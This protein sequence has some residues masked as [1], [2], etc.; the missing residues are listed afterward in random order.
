[1]TQESG[2]SSA[3]PPPPKQFELFTTENVE[4]FKRDPDSVPDHIARAMRPPDLPEQAYSIFGEMWQ[5]SDAIQSLEEAGVQRLYGQ[6]YN[7]LHE[8]RKL[9]RSLLLNFLELV[10]VMSSAPEQV[11]CP[12]PDLP[13]AWH[14]LLI[15]YCLAQSAVKE[16]KYSRSR[17]TDL[18]SS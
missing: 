16:E 14:I 12:P 5:L 7:L 18:V 6:D 4:A 1:M 2:F 17:L 8:L 15:Y 11:I 3:F 10:T 9:S 13:I